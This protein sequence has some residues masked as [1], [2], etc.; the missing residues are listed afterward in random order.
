MKMQPGFVKPGQI[1]SV[2]HV[3]STMSV[4]TKWHS[5]VIITRKIENAI[6]DYIILNSA[7]CGAY[8][9]GNADLFVDDSLYSNRTKTFWGKVNDVSELFAAHGWKKPEKVD[10]LQNSGC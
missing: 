7:G 3:V 1:H 10:N 5:Y 9:K 6:V 8:M 2:G 4:D